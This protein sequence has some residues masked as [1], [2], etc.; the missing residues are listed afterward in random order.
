[1]IK[2]AV[3]AEADP[4]SNPHIASS[5]T[6]PPLQSAPAVIHTRESAIVRVKPEVAE[7]TIPRT[8]KT[9]SRLNRVSAGSASSRSST[10]PTSRDIPKRESTLV[11]VIPE[12]INA[13]KR[14]SDVALSENP[15][16]VDS[17]A[18]SKE[19]SSKTKT[20]LIVS[21]TPLGQVTN[22]PIVRPPRGVSTMY[23]S[24]VM[25]GSPIFDDPRTKLENIEI[26]MS[27]QESA[28]DRIRKKPRLSAEDHWTIA[29][30][31]SL[32]M[33]SPMNEPIA[34]RE[35]V[36]DH[37]INRQSHPLTD[38]KANVPQPFPMAMEVDRRPFI[39]PEEPPALRNTYENP[40]IAADLV[41]RIGINVPPPIVN[42][43][44]DDNGDYYGRG[45]DLFEGPRASADEYV[46]CSLFQP[47]K[48]F[49]DDTFSRTIALKSSSLPPVMSKHSTG[50]KVW[51]K[52]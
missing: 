46:I 39:K 26:A 13:R 21:K 11:S 17:F 6:I 52:L 34:K 7:S 23:P 10:R 24:M 37:I 33:D 12:V 41:N 47:L 3:K 48:L 36:D 43:A 20:D 28:L 40:T 50:T 29:D 8:S 4:A 15:Q 2:G 9:R 38:R 22:S 25:N 51:T 35:P 1:M 30:P 44:Q 32:L 14:P 49:P 16:A 42:D 27:I 45:A 31:R 5:H 18:N 19:S